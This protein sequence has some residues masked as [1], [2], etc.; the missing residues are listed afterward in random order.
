MRSEVRAGRR[1]GVRGSGGGGRGW[2]AAAALAKRRTI[3]PFCR[4]HAR[5][6]ERRSERRLR[7][8]GVSGEKARPDSQLSQAL[9][10]RRGGGARAVPRSARVTE[11]IC[12]TC[13]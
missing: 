3:M 8:S 11:N 2:G 12:G 7:G 5:G 1:E 10:G 6:R 13:A 9:G 4:A